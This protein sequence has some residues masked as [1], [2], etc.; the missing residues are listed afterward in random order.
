YERPAGADLASHGFGE[1]IDAARSRPDRVDEQKFHRRPHQRDDDDDADKRQRGVERAIEQ[2]CAR[3]RR[4]GRARRRRR[5]GF[6]H[7]AADVGRL[8]VDRH[9]RSATRIWALYQFISAL[10]ES[11]VARERA[12]V[13]GLIWL[14]W[15]VWCRGVPAKTAKGWG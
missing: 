5:L 13:M 6:E 14:A 3:A 10:G 8:R 11:E 2:P 4:R 1:A 9:Q 15:R 7:G 12:M